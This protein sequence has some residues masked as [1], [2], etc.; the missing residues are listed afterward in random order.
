M[1]KQSIIDH[2]QRIRILDKFEVALQLDDQRLLVPSFMPDIC[3]KEFQVDEGLYN[4]VNHEAHQAPLRRLWFSE[5]IPH[6]FWPR[7]ICRIV[8]DKNIAGVS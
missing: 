8:K 4:N 3:P 1:R 5:Y 7:L 6:G 2:R